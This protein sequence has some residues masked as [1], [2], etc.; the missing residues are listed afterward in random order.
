MEHPD[1]RN[2]LIGR[3][4]EAQRLSAAILDRESLLIWGPVDAGK[5]ALA[6][7][8]LRGL[9]ARQ[10]GNCIYWSGAASVK[11]LA[12]EIVRGLHRAGDPVVRKRA[13]DAGANPDSIDHWLRERTSGQ[14]KQ[15]LFAALPKGRY[16]IFLDHVAPSSR[17]MARLLK[18]IIWRCTTP[19]YLL[20]RGYMHADIGHAWSNYFADRYR[21][22]VDAVSESAARRIFEESVRRFGI[23]ASNPT[24]FREDIVHLSQ[25]IPGRIVKMCA[26]AGDPRYVCEGQIKAKLLHVDYWVAQAANV[27]EFAAQST[28]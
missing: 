2:S 5:T 28:G 1:S 14:L 12:G 11:Q 6:T 4:A 9:P 19:V 13:G 26:M 17:P 15:L 22:H 23:T 24:K 10:R 27:P 8:V 20:A 3:E 18:E 25:R 21:I 16:W 7:A